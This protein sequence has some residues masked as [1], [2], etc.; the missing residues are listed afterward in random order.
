MEEKYLIEAIQ[1]LKPSAEFVLSDGD[2]STIKWD[3]LEGVAPTMAEIE[4]KIEQIKSDEIAAKIKAENNRL[5][6]QAKLEAL[7]LTADDLKALGL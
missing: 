5:A 6:A 4:T 1:S 2:Y 3:E 7:G